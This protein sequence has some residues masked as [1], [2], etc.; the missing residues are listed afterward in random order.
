ME[1]QELSITLTLGE[2]NNVIG[3]LMDGRYGQVAPLIE[4]IRN[5]ATAQLN[6][7]PEEQKP[8]EPK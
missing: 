2:W 3:V 4:K 8:E 1:N 6:K 7:L 5:Q